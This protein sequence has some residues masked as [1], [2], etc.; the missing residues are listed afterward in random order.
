MEEKLAAYFSDPCVTDLLLSSRSSGVD[1]SGCIENQ[2]PIGTEEELRLWALQVLGRMGRSFDAKNP[3]NDGVLE[4]A[5]GPFRF[6]SIFPPL[7]R[8]GIQISLRRLPRAEKE[9]R[10]AHWKSDPHYAFLKAACE[11]GDNL[12]VCGSTGSGKTT[13]VNELLSELSESERVLSLE[14]TPELAPGLPGHVSL[15]SR[16]PNADGFGEVTLRALLKQTLRMR[17][18]RIILGECRGD[19]VLDLLQALNT[20][21]RGTLATLHASSAREGVK[22]LELLCMLSGNTTLTL[23]AIRELIALSIKWFVFVE[24]RSDGRK[25]REVLEVSGREGDTLLFRPLKLKEG[26]HSLGHGV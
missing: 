13:L 10:P 20:G 26:I 14:D 18:D 24:R 3:F 23:S 1:R 22:R 5:S 21:H 9:N 7:S 17:P 15:V 8:G 25:I 11:R 2:P 12:I 16:P 4:T 6:H 19:E